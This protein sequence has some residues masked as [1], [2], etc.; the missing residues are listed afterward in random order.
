MCRR[1]PSV[2]DSLQ[3]VAIVEIHVPT[4]RREI[5]AGSNECDDSGLSFQAGRQILPRRSVAIKAASVRFLV[6]NISVA[7][8]LRNGFGIVF[9]LFAAEIFQDMLAP[10]ALTKPVQSFCFAGLQDQTLPCLLHLLGGAPDHIDAT[11]DFQFRGSQREE[12]TAPL[13]G[14]RR[15]GGK[16]CI[17]ALNLRAFLSGL[18]ERGFLLVKLMLLTGQFDGPL[19]LL[20]LL[21]L[22]QAR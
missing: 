1:T 19:L 17:G 9:F 4:L 13:A 5:E 20:G 11:R 3:P 7:D 14:P 15:S 12:R 21:D 18:G 16:G 10:P 6:R 8:E 22:Q 2:S